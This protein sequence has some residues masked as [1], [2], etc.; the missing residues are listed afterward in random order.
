MSNSQ[1]RNSDGEGTTGMVEEQS[2]PAGAGETGTT[3]FG[4]SEGADSDGAGSGGVLHELAAG[5]QSDIGA[6]SGGSGNA[7][8]SGLQPGGIAPGGG[9]AAM[10]GSLGT[11]G[12]S[13]ANQATG[14]A[15]ENAIDE[16]VK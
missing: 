10:A 16:E 4:Q 2:R 15:D 3:R 13:N 8:S 9:P 5:R 1:G 12:G 14:D 6:S 11:G 7:L